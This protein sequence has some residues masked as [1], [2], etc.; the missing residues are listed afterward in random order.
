MALYWYNIILWL[1][2][3]NFFHKHSIKCLNQRV[4]K[5]SKSLLAMAVGIKQK[6]VVDRI[7]EKVQIR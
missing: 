2:V 1:I 6:T 5:A 7:V 3:S 4:A